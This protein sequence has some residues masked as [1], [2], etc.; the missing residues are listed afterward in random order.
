MVLDNPK[1]RNSRFRHLVGAAG[2]LENRLFE[3]LAAADLSD[4]DVSCR[5]MSGTSLL[6]EVSRKKV[7]LSSRTVV[8]RLSQTPAMMMH[9]PR[10]GS[11]RPYIVILHY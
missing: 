9:V 1:N 2:A 5:T 3:M 4:S 8:L 7:D 11:P 6:D 10:P